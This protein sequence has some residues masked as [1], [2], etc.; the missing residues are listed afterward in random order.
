MQILYDLKVKSKLILLMSVAALLAI[1]VGF[2]GLIGVRS[3]NDSLRTV[4]EDRVVCLKQ[5]KVVADMYA[6]NIVDAS[7]K[8]RNGNISWQEAMKQYN[9]AKSTIDNEWRQYTST[10][11]VPQENKLVDETEQE[12]NK[13]NSSLVKLEGIL[14]K[15]DKEALASYTVNELYQNIDPISAKVS[16]LVELQLSIAQQEYSNA[17]AAYQKM[18]LIFLVT[19]LCG[20]GMCALIGVIII[21]SMTSQLGLIQNSIQTDS[22]GNVSIKAIDINT[23]DEFGDLAN[24]LNKVTEQIRVFINNTSDSADTVAASAQQL[25]ASADESATAVNEVAA[26]ITEVSDGAREQAN[27]IAE[28]SAVVAN[29]SIGISKISLSAQ[30]MMAASNETAIAANSGGQAIQNAVRQMNIIEHSVADSAQVIAKLNERS[31]KIGQIVGTITNIA[32]QT[33]LLA[34]NAAIE[35]ARAGEHG[36]GFSV[37]AEEVRKL[38]EQAEAAADQITNLISEVQAETEKAVESMV[39]GTQETKNGTV[40]VNKAGEAFSR[41]STEIERTSEQIADVTAAIKNISEDSLRIVTAVKTIETVSKNTA[42]QTQTVSASTEE[43]SAALEEIA[44]SSQSL[45][46]MAEQLQGAIKTFRM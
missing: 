43:Q 34:L 8:A 25:T 13:A 21:R 6:V 2:V 9:E 16:E 26:I 3:S 36:R 12:M 10:Y 14:Q 20:L 37:V 42:G 5:L 4:Y 7:H 44:A 31:V 28:T 40:I 18:Q 45:A 11:L 24:S 35:A 27:A 41:I 38:A 22:N 39:Q 46:Q 1:I 33:N 19:L 15:Q 32:G 17:Q 23:K 29:M 30:S